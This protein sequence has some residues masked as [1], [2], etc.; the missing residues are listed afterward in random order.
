[1]LELFIASMSLVL[2]F[3]I[4]RLAIGV[5]FHAKEGLYYK[6]VIVEVLDYVC[7]LMYIVMAIMLAVSL[8]FT[9]VYGK[10]EVNLTVISLSIVGL[11]YI[12]ERG[13]KM[14]QSRNLI[15][16]RSA[17]IDLKMLSK[18]APFDLI[19]SA[20]LNEVTVDMDKLDELDASLLDECVS[21]YQ[22]PV[23]K[24]WIKKV[25]AL[26][27]PAVIAIVILIAGVVLEGQQGR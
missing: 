17:Y 24:T 14:Y 2:I 8:E 6:S 11:L 10:G 9:G 4:A 26:L 22:L 5:F 15:S 25:L 27:T 7:V 20:S 19:I 13:Y 23:K 3:T 12:C 16:I 1:M 18:V 21:E